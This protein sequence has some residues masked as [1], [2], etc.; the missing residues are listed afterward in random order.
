MSQ[1]PEVKKEEEKEPTPEEP[2]EEHKEQ[3]KPELISLRRSDYYPLGQY[4]QEDGDEIAPLKTR[5][6]FGLGYVDLSDM[7]FEKLKVRGTSV[8]SEI[9]EK[10][11][12]NHA[13]L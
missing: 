6:L 11:V 1:A 5:G 10:M 9:V 8:P 7:K 4:D 13:I 12:T 3:R 2:P